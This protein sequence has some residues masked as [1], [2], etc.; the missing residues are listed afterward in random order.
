MNIH[1]KG[2]TMLKKSTCPNMEGGHESGVPR[3]HGQKKKRNKEIIT[4]CHVYKGGKDLDGILN[5]V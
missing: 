1:P 3:S 4:G 2:I 5:Q